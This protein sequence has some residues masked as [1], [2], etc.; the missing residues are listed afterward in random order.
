MPEVDN[1]PV[2]Q[3]AIWAFKAHVPDMTKC[4]AALREVI[5]AGAWR[6][7]Q[8]PLGARCEYGEFREWVEAKVPRGLETTIANLG[9]IA[10]NDT[11]LRDAIDQA[12]K[13][14]GG[15]PTETFDN[16]QGSSSAP[17]G[18]AKDAALRRLRKDRPDLHAEVLAGKKSPHA[19]MVEAKFRKRTITV[20]VD[21]E[22]AARVLKRHFRVSQLID[23]LEATQKKDG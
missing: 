14:E 23:A 3:T 20:P 1:W 9:E 19:A 6:S 17:T 22:G 8:P 21:V 2:V 10:G 5:I 16:I 7:Y 13:R 4:R 12:T 11:S 18:T 15:R